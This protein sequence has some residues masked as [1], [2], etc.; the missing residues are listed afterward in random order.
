MTNLTEVSVGLDVDFLQSMGSWLALTCIRR[1]IN[2]FKVVIKQN[3]FL[4]CSF[5][6]VS[7]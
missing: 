5:L 6:A 3:Y 4:L 2:D 7:K 1:K